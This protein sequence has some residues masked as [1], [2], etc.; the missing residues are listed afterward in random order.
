MRTGMMFVFGTFV[1][2][3]A[4]MLPTLIMH[5]HAHAQTSPG[6]ALAHTEESFEFTA[7]G[8]MEKVGPLFGADKERVW[9]PGWNPEFVWP[10]PAADR[11]GMVFRVSHGEHKST[12]VNTRLDLKS[13][14]V[15]YAYV[16][17]GALTTLITIKFEPRGNETHVTVKYERT[18]LNPEAG[19]H[20][21]QLAEQDRKSGPEWEGQINAYLAKTVTQSK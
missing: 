8:A 4:M 7:K 18:A 21:K 15:Q 19:D 10:A 20:V 11:E 2:I 5:I 6:S 1:G 16:I 17:A 13:G 3:G 9:A 14:D 12:W